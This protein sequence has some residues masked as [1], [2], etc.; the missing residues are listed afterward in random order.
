MVLPS[1]DQSEAIALIV[2][3]SSSARY[4]WDAIRQTA[5]RINI[6]LG[7][8][9][10]EALKLFAFGNPK[11]ISLGTLDQSSPPDAN[12]SQPCSLIAPIMEQLLDDPKTHSVIIVGN[13]EVF[14]LDDWTGDPRFNG[15]LLVCA[16]EDTL[17]KPTNRVAEINAVQLDGDGD[18]LRERFTQFSNHI[19]SRSSISM[20]VGNFTWQ[21]DSTGYPLIYV[22]PLKTYVHLFPVTKPQFERFIASGRKIKS[23]DEWYADVLA[24][25]PR[26]SYRS[27]DVIEREQLF[28]TGVT[29]DDALAFGRWLGRG[30][31]L[32]TAAD[33][34]ECREWFSRPASSV[35]PDLA[36]QLSDDAFAI[37]N[38][39]ENEWL[40]QSEEL[41]LQ[42]LSLMRQGILEWVVDLPG[43]YYAVGDPRSAKALRTVY[44]PVRPLG[45]EAASLRN[46]GFRLAKR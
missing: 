42:Q 11:P 7:L 10:P 19:E 22:N 27:E 31:K 1:P 44:D 12:Q 40:E 2:D 41:N 3:T 17:K 16:G 24:S 33:W 35:P 14:D 13:G 18:T 21:V 20:D 30:Y 45:T 39:I 29:T 15:W 37:W 26:G 8:E 32:L 28:T 38:W 43:T 5:L 34:R 46:I 25:N 4:Y 6:L 23:D 9:D 36:T